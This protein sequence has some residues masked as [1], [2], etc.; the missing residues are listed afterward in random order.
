MQVPLQQS[1]LTEQLAPDARQHVMPRPPVV[2]VPAQQS[3]VAAHVLPRATHAPHWL[4]LRQTRLLQHGGAV[5]PHAS[6]V[7]PQVHVL[8]AHAS[9]EQQSAVPP[10]PPPEEVQAP[11]W[12]FARQTRLCDT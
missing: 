10:Q 6:P 4:L 9:P 11:H 2:Q 1:V 12:L 7:L 3:P 5:P 8:P